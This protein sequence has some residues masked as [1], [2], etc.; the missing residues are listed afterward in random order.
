MAKFG[1]GVNVLMAHFQPFIHKGLQ[2]FINTYDPRPVLMGMLLLKMGA[3]PFLND[4]NV[5]NSVIRIAGR[6]SRC[7]SFFAALLG[8]TVLQNSASVIAL[9]VTIAISGTLPQS[10]V[11]PVALGSHLG[12]TVTILL[13]AAGGR[14]NACMLGVATFLYK[15]TGILAFAPLVPF[16]AAL[17]CR[18]NFPMPINIVLAQA[19][20]VFWN[21]AIFYPWPQ[22]LVHGSMFVLSHTRN[23]DLGLPVYLDENLTDIP[24]L[25]VRLLFKEMVRLCNYNGPK[26]SDRKRWGM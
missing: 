4:P 11:F 22:I 17:L 6:P 24:S 10:A 14:R 3:D 20:L 15:L 25:A 2:T 26:K 1:R 12:S 13:A 9:V 7:S 21:A 18:L 5:R 16:S 8:T 19:F 23:I